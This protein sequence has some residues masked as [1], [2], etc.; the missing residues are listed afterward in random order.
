MFGQF[1]LIA[2]RTAEESAFLDLIAKT[3]KNSFG[4]MT[5]KCFAQVSY[6]SNR[7]KHV[8]ALPC[9]WGWNGGSSTW[10]EPNDFRNIPTACTHIHMF[11]PLLTSLLGGHRF[12]TASQRWR[13]AGSK[14]M[15]H[16]HAVS[17]PSL[18]PLPSSSPVYFIMHEK[19]FNLPFKRGNRKFQYCIREK[20]STGETLHQT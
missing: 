20:D 6:K 8:C 9:G 5:L 2:S 3:C 1:G 15:P 14:N 16:H 13:D 7:E 10:P 11:T 4:R 12:A 19:D 17:S 18:L